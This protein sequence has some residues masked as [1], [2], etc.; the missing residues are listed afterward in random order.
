M[1]K[2]KHG[3]CVHNVLTRKPSYAT[4]LTKTISDTVDSVAENVQTSNR[5]ISTRSK[6]WTA[7]I[8]LDVWTNEHYPRIICI[9]YQSEITDTCNGSKDNIPYR[10]FDEEV[11]ASSRLCG[12]ESRELRAISKISKLLMIPTKMII[13]SPK[14]LILT[15]V[16][17]SSLLLWCCDRVER[18]QA[19]YSGFALNR[20]RLQSY[21]DS[22]KWSCLSKKAYV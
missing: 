17:V 2:N 21:I 8:C 16:S 12:V 4:L 11:H 6:E 13:Q 22:N 20:D 3:L 19:E 5:G 1:V 7:I 14:D 18:Q 15:Y 10:M 9:L